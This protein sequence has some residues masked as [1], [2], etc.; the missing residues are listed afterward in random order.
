L[1]DIWKFGVQNRNLNLIWIIKFGNKKGNGKE[2]RKRKAL[3]LGHGCTIGPPQLSLR[4]AQLEILRADLCGPDVSRSQ[5]R[6]LV[7]TLHLCSVGPDR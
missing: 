2:K 7:C 1:C 5:P 4:V 3:V 6:A